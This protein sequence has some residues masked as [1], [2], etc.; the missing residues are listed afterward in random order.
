MKYLITAGFLAATFFFLGCESEVTIPEGGYDFYPDSPYAGTQACM[1]CHESIYSDFV[2]SG[3]NYKLNKVVDGQPPTYPFTALSGPPPGT[4]W[5]DVTYVIGGY[6][7]KARF[8]GTDGYIITAGGN[9]QYNFETGEWV[10]YH[11]DETKPYD[12]GRCHTTGYDETGH[13]GGL[14]GIEGTWVMEGVQCENCHGPGDDHTKAPVSNPMSINTS[15]SLCGECHIRGSKYTIPAK[16]GFTRHHEQYNEHF[17]SVMG[18]H[19][20]CNDCHD[21][22]KRAVH[23]GD[24]IKIG[25]DDCHTEQLNNFMTTG[26]DCTDCHMPELAKSAVGDAAKF[27]GD[28][29]THLW[30]INIDPNAEQFYTE[31]DNDYSYFYINLDF[32]C[33]KCHNDKDRTWAAA[34]AAM[35]HG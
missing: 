13:Q 24:A 21:A 17:N 19:L 3:H 34:N 29:H 7:W 20:T 9:N 2:N 12:C 15:S 23:N 10:D 1:I 22:H 33:L 31:G 5:S 28:V 32:A 26:F 6:K 4:T 27:D 11:A 35:V 14:E 16:G 8:V 30:T 18:E 25:C